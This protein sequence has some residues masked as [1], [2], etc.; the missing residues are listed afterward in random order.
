[1][2]SVVV[3]AHGV[4]VIYSKIMFGCSSH[5]LASDIHSYVHKIIAMDGKGGKS[6]DC[7]LSY[8]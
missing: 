7:S 6:V 8:M 4:Y 5:D 3:R 2:D 1:M